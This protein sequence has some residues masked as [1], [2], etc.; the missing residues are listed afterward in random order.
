MHGK[1]A[2]FDKLS[3]HGKFQKYGLAEFAELGKF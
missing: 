1:F 2:E 3:E